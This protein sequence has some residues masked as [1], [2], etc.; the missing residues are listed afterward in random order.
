MKFGDLLWCIWFFQ[1]YLNQLL[2]SDLFDNPNGGHFSTLTRSLQNPSFSS[3]QS[4]QNG[5]LGLTRLAIRCGDRFFFLC[6]GGPVYR[7]LSQCTYYKGNPS[8]WPYI[9]I[10]F[11]SPPTWV[12][13][14]MSP[15]LCWD[16]KKDDFHQINHH[17]AEVEMFQKPLNTRKTHTNINQVPGCS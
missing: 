13:I 16:L 11:D 14:Q 12:I 5:R 2:P 15:G 10:K 4:T 8:K 7:G 6:I 17:L 3:L 9:Y 1:T